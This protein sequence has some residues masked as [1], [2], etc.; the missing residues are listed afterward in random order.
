MTHWLGSFE[1]LISSSLAPASPTK[2]ARTDAAIQKRDNFIAF[3]P[4]SVCLAA[5]P[6]AYVPTHVTDLMSGRD[7]LV[8]KCYLSSA[9]STSRGERSRSRRCLARYVALASP[10]QQAP[11]RMLGQP[12]RGIFLPARKTSR[13]GQILERPLLDARSRGSLQ[14]EDKNKRGHELFLASTEFCP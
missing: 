14:T 11:L 2:K 1:S 9:T 4:P 12:F 10:P 5:S 7:R 3:V 13:Q 6:A 8:T